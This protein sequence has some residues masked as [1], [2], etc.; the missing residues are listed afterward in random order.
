MNVLLINPP[1]YDFAAHD[2][3]LKPYGLV[4]IAGILKNSGINSIYFFDFMDRHIFPHAKSDSYGRGKFYSEEV[5]KPEI[6]GFIPRKFKRYGAPIDIF[7]KFLASIPSPD[8]TLIS[9]GMTYWYLGVKESI[10]M[11]RDVYPSTKVILGGIY[12]SIL[13]EHAKNY[14]KPDHVFTDLD[15]LSEFLG[16]SG[17]QEDSSP[18]WKVYKKLDYGVIKLQMGAPLGVHT[19]LCGC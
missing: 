14:L 3:W 8:F 10:D 5:E 12:S 15:I 18:I 1:I 9:T 19:A 7:Y 6:L 16:V 2:F 13:P 17:L 11:V 4:H